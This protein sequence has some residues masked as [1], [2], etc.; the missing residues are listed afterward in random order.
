M[1]IA[2]DLGRKATKQTNKAPIDW[3]KINQNIVWNHEANISGEQFRL[4]KPLVSSP[5]HFV[6]KVTQGLSESFV[7]NNLLYLNRIL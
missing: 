7:V 6:L 4:I 1:T 2:V 3:L 5:E